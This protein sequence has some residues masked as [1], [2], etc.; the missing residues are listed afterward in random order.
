MQQQLLTVVP[1]KKPAIVKASNV[2]RHFLNHSVLNSPDLVMQNVA[3]VM[4]S[5][6]FVSTTLSQPLECSVFASTLALKHLCE[7]GLA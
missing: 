6:I 2:V 1:R 5:L 4:T 7:G 3:A